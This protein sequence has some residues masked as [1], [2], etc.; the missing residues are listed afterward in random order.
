MSARSYLTFTDR[1]GTPTAA[2]EALVAWH[3][4]LRKDKGL[5]AALRRVRHPD[6]CAFIPGFH[7]LRRDL[8]AH[9]HIDP[10]TLAVA[11]A[12]V[13]HVKEHRPGVPLPARLRGDRDER[14]PLSDLR[15]RRLLVEEDPAELLRFLRRAVHILDASVDLPDMAER[16][17]R[18][19]TPV[20][21]DAAA[22]DFAYAYYGALTPEERDDARRGDTGDAASA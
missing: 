21:H 4:D 17:R 8:K 14:A 11:A 7:D 20:L 16:V 15:L 9:G 12:L 10:E 22:R 2:G 13:A 5:R 1:R 3:A 6:D 19:C 18:L